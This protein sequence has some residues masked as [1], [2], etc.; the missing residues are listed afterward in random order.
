VDVRVIAATNKNLNQEIEL[1]RFREDLLY[2]L[3]VVPIHAFAAR[4]T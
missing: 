3:N 2:R 1:G 4:A